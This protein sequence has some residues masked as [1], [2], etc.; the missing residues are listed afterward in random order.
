MCTEKCFELTQPPAARRAGSGV[1]RRAALVG[2]VA[3]AASAALQSTAQAGER[4]P[5]FRA[6]GT[7]CA[8]SPTS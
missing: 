2:G 6:G 1:S 5:A 3:V 4:G 7:A 8:T